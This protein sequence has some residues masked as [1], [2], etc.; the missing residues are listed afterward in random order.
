MGLFLQKF[1]IG[2]KVSTFG[3]S[4]FQSFSIAVASSAQNKERQDARANAESLHSH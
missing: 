2:M 4:V 3:I 1:A